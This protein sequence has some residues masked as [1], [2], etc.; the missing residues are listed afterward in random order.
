MKELTPNCSAREVFD[1]MY[2]K[3]I[4]GNE[5]QRREICLTTIALCPLLFKPKPS[6]VSQKNNN[7]LLEGMFFEKVDF[8]KAMITEFEI[9]QK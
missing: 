9:L 8:V 7:F 3:W 6:I 5:T 1:I 2:P 4:E